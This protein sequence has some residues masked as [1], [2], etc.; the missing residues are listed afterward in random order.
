MCT[1]T[2]IARR[3]GFALGMNRDEKLTRVTALP[4]AEHQVGHH[5]A[6]FPSEPTGGTW[7]GVNDAGACLALINW[8]SVPVT[9]RGEALSR[10]NV[11]RSTLQSATSVSVNRIVAGMPL[12]RTNPFRLIGI[13]PEAKEV[14]EWRWNLS[15]LESVP[16]RWENNTWISSG[17]DEPGAQQIRTQTF[18]EARRQATADSLNWL[19]RLHRSHGP[20]RGPFSFCMHRDDAATASYTEIVVSRRR[21]TLRYLPGAPCCISALSVQRLEIIRPMKRSIA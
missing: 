7:L 11:V 20:Q 2:F 3:H 17:H 6:L 1:V 15:L 8:Y 10:G 14:I 19:R 12:H 4:P 9:V 18:N 16:H 21:A 13:F 5:K